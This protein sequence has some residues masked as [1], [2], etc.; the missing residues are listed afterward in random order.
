MTDPGCTSR[1]GEFDLTE[2]ETVA[3]E[4]I[5]EEAV[6]N[7]YVRTRQPTLGYWLTGAPT[8]GAGSR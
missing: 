5:D 8:L 1:S 2:V 7:R 3:V 6:T 4:A